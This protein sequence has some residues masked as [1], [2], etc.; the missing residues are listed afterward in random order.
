[1]NAGGLRRLQ[2]SLFM[3]TNKQNK[4]LATLPSAQTLEALY[5]RLFTAEQIAVALNLPLYYF[6]DSRKRS[7]MGIPCYCINRLV[8]YRIREVHKW[9]VE[10]TANLAARTRVSAMKQPGGVHA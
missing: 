9:Q 8:R 3:K 4:L 5:E 7:E 1:M 2:G 6:K 10:Y